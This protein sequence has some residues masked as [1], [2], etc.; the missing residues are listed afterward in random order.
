M[1]PF[2]QWQNELKTKRMV[3]TLNKRG[4][5][6]FYMASKEEAKEAIIKEVQKGATIALGGSESLTELGLVD[7]FSKGE[8]KVFERYSQPTWEETVEVYRQS[9]LADYL[10]T[11]TNIITEDGKLMNQDS[12][13]NRA[14]AIVFGPKK[15]I[16][17][18][19][20][21]KIVKNLE[22]GFERLKDIS[23]MNCRRVGHHTPCAVTGKCEDC[24]LH[25]RMC[26]FTTIVH[27]GKKF[28]GRY[29]I[30]LVPE[31]MGF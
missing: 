20:V 22:V 29:S 27:N 18:A 9:M 14:A 23:P 4:Y 25:D 3:E 21:N 5:S 12:T 2:K 16:I 1:N 15:V 7:Y 31:E 10:I 19:S 26:N 11:S 24:E 17:I 6:A 13:G 28:P 8:Y 30:Y